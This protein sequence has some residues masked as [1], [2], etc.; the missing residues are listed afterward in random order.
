[1]AG[2]QE[3]LWREGGREVMQTPESGCF[4]LERSERYGSTIDRTGERRRRE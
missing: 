4:S 3:D 1:M 2:G